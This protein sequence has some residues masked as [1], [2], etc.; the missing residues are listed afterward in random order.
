MDAKANR[1]SAQTA[2]AHRI[3]ERTA[4][5][6]A[7]DFPGPDARHSTKEKGTQNIERSGKRDRCNYRPWL[8]A[9]HCVPF[10]RGPIKWSHEARGRP[11]PRDST[12]PLCMGLGP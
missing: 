12:L 8:A 3:P 10:V 4:G 7:K 5:D 2:V 6:V 11:W 9:L 1:R